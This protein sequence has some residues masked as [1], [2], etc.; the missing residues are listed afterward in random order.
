[1]TP[2]LTPEEKV[3]ALLDRVQ[4][5]VRDRWNTLPPDTADRLLSQLGELG[6]R[7]AGYLEGRIPW[8][9]PP[10]F[11]EIQ[12]PIDGAEILDLFGNRGP[13]LMRYQILLDGRDVLSLAADIVGDALQSGQL[14]RRAA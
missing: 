9:Q 12:R 1:M 6:D 5:I 11:V 4:S 3:R 14:L 13:F 10:Q 8:S 2:G 7:C